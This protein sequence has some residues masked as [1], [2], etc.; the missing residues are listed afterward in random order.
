MRALV[1]SG[2]RVG[3][4]ERPAPLPG[5]DEITVRV[6]AAGLCRTDVLVAEGRIEASD[7]VVLGHELAGVVHALGGEVRGLAIGAHVTVRPFLGC[8]AC[9]AC[10]RGRDELCADARMLGIHLDGAFAEQL[11][12]PARLVHLLPPGVTPRAG[13]YAEPVAAVLAAR[14]VIGEGE[15]GVVLGD[16]RIAVLTARVLGAA[17]VAI[18]LAT[19]PRSIESSSVDFAIE[20]MPTAE[21]LREAVRVVRPGGTVVLKSRSS[22]S[23]EIPLARAIE[24][25]VTFRALRYGAFDDAIRLLAR[26]A[27]DDLFGET[28]SIEEFDRAFAAAARDERQKR[29]FAFGDVDVWDR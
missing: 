8:G 26:L 7:P 19:E 27:L 17:G 10:A 13:A 25:Q 18:E 23:A 6:I 9:A 14:E 11:R 3:V 4:S 12:V 21:V 20:S 24:K 22:R 29:F 28:L 1:R 2:G 15:T 5:A 16:N